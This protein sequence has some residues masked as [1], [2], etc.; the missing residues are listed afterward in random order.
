MI[1]EIWKFRESEKK[2]F[3]LYFSGWC[4]GFGALVSFGGE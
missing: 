1:L 4:G 3:Q 2:F